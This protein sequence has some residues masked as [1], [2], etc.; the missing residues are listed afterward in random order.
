MPEAD[1]STFLDLVHRLTR[2]TPGYVLREDHMEI[3]L[4]G[5]LLEQLRQAMFGGMEGTGGSSSF[6]S[7]P[8]IDTGALDLLNEITDQAT[9]VLAAVTGKPTPYGQAE[10]YVREWSDNTSEDKSFVVTS[11]STTINGAIF[12]ERFEYTAFHLAKRW[13][14]RIEDFFEPPRTREVKAPCPSCGHRYVYRVKDGEVIQSPAVHIR[15]D[16]DTGLSIDAR[17]SNCG[18]EWPRSKFEVLAKLVG[19]NPVPELANDMPVITSL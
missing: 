17:C 19:A 9:V 2:E 16:R 8:P 11:R 3:R 5:G 10:E 13:V 15:L 7:K 14:Q 4:R 18:A 6:G 12:D 1:E